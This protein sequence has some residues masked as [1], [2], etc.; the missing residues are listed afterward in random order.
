MDNPSFDKF[1]S[2]ID[3]NNSVIKNIIERKS[4]RKLFYSTHEKN[5]K[6]TD[7]NG[8]L[9]DYVIKAHLGM[10][11]NHIEVIQFFAEIYRENFNYDL[12]LKY[13]NELLFLRVPSKSTSQQYISTL[14]PWIRE[15][16]SMDSFLHMYSKKL[17]DSYDAQK[18]NMNYRNVNSE[19]SDILN[20]MFE[21]LEN[22]GKLVKIS[23][24]RFNEY[25]NKLVRIHLR[26]TIKDVKYPQYF[27]KVP[28]KKESLEIIEPVNSYE[29]AEWATTVK[30]CVY[31]YESKILGGECAIFL[32]RENGEPKFTVEV[33]H[34]K[35]SNSRRIGQ[36]EKIY[37]SQM[38][39]EE[40]DLAQ[41]VIQEIIN[42]QI[43]H[44]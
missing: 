38:T 43:S 44:K 4:F 34:P 26:A 6:V 23:P 14:Y 24:L 37:K 18:W 3:T 39:K 20:M 13:I 11:T 32:I 19:F 42:K 35:T 16:I 33:N 36:I 40:H 17:K 10:M 1:I 9:G 41:N 25:H 8:G 2:T 30:N 7:G 27:L 15:N 22:G 5:V 31:S 28:Y 12:V 21:I 29:L